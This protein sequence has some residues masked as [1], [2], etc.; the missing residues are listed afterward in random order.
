MANRAY[1]GGFL[2][3]A[4]AAPVATRSTALQHQSATEVT[5][6]RPI[7]LACD[8][9]HSIVATIPGVSIQR[10]KGLF[11]H[12]ALQDPV[13]GCRLVIT[14]SFEDAPPGEDAANRLRDGFAARV[15]QEMLAYSADGK[16]GTAFA[17]RKTEVACLFR[18]MWNGGFDGEP[19]M[20]R[21]PA[22]TVSVLCTSPVPPQERR[23]Q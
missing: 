23:R 7:Q 5:P 4:L 11:T 13:R 17:L 18:G 20:P 19:S 12:E 3:L 9:A 15:W 16:D 14:G 22:Y 10:S 6:E 8:L 21:E 1:I 2:F